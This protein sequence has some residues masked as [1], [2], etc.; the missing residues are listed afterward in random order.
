MLLKRGILIVAVLAL[1]AAACGDD[2]ATDG[3]DTGGGT[4]ASSSLDATAT[5]FAFAPTSWTVSSG[6]TVTV[7][8]TNDGAVEHN[9]VVVG[10]GKTVA[11]AAELADSDMLVN[12]NAAAGGSGQGSFTAPAAGTYQV[13]CS[14]PGHLPAGMEATLTVN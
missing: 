8:L 4:T 11:D 9:L 5:E 14:I 12:V 7:N 2:D 3:G 10:G 6:A 1:V 13:I